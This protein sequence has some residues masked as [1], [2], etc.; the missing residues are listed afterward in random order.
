M[1][2]TLAAMEGR[3]PLRW[4]DTCVTVRAPGRAQIAKHSK[5]S[6]VPTPAPM[7][8][9][10]TV[11]LMTTSVGKHDQPESAVARQS[12]QMQGVCER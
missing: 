1:T 4:E 3:A 9:P 2:L 11:S 5:T 6:A 8:P 10:A 7:A 12:L